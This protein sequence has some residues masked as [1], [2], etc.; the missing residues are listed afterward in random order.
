MENVGNLVDLLLEDAKRIRIRQHQR[1]D[2]FVHLGL[3][4]RDVHHSAGV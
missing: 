3:E 2:F 4:G 1:G